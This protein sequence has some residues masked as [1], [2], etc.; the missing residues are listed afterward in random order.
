MTFVLASSSPRRKQLLEQIGVSFTQCSISI[1][2]TPAA[3]ESAHDYVV[4]MAREKALQGKMQN[5]NDALVIA[6]DTICTFN[7]K[8]L[9]KP[10]NRDH[11]REMLKTFSGNTHSVV[12]AVAIAANNQLFQKLVE[13]EVNFRQISDAEINDYWLSGEPADKA[14]AYGIQ[15]IGGKFVKTINGSYSAVV[16]LPLAETDELIKIALGESNR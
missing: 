8:I 6:A 16:G 9:G 5:T 13:T 2:E 3:D 14:G 4:R 15:G 10:T 12:T 7:G 1:D 11:A